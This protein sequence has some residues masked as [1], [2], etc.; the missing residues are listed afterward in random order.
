MKSFFPTL[1]CFNMA[2]L[3]VLRTVGKA[4]LKTEYSPSVL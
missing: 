4:I 1:T 2:I 3:D